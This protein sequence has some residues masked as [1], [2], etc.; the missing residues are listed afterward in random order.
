LL[1]QFGQVVRRSG[2]NGFVS[3]QE[4]F[5]VYG[6]DVYLWKTYWDQCT[7]GDWIKFNIHVNKEGFPQVCWMER[8]GPGEVPEG[9]GGNPGKGQQGAF[10]FGGGDQGWKRPAQNDGIEYAKRI[11][12]GSAASINTGV[13][14]T[15]AQF[16]EAAPTMQQWSQAG[17]LPT[18]GQYMGQMPG[19]MPGG[20]MQGQMPGQM[21]MGQMPGQ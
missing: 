16:G 9:K 17:T 5:A 20:Q 13:A 7:L 21:G 14:P 10:A 1:I 18:M 8:M 12:M 11:A 15:M 6:R 4:T 19:Q 2:D 3:C